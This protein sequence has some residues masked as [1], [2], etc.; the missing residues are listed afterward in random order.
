MTMIKSDSY[1]NPP[2]E[3][4]FESIKTRYF[5]AIDK[6]NAQASINFDAIEQYPELIKI[7]KTLQLISYALKSNDA[8]AIEV[9][10]TFVTSPVYFHYSGY[11]RETM[12]RRL[13][14]CS[15]TI[16]QQKAIISGVESIIKNKQF[17]YEFKEISKL[18]NR[19]KELCK[20]KRAV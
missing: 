13:K 10:V 6:A 8:G 7:K 17:S 9:S 14:H 19:V 1:H 11:I 20:C 18:Y 2:D 15:M 4:S 16:E 3:W 12:A 5:E